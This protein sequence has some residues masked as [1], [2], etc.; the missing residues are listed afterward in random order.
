MAL[1][2]RTIDVATSTHSHHGDTGEFNVEFQC[3]APSNFKIFT[4]APSHITAPPPKVHVASSFP[5]DSRQIIGEVKAAKQAAST[6]T[7]ARRPLI[8]YLFVHRR[9]ADSSYYE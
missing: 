4:P 1:G 3:C 7:H 6:M 2:A 9:F 5:S 8:C